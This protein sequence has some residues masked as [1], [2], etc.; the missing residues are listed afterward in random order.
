MYPTKFLCL[1]RPDVNRVRRTCTRQEVHRSSSRSVSHRSSAD[2]GRAWSTVDDIA[3]TS[4]K[5]TSSGGRV[6]KSARLS[7]AP[8]VFEFECGSDASLRPLPRR[9]RLADDETL[10]EMHEIAED[11]TLP[12]IHEIADRGFEEAANLMLTLCQPN[13]MEKHGKSR[14]IQSQIETGT[15][16]AI[17]YV[18]EEIY[19]SWGVLPTLE[20][21]GYRCETEFWAQ[22]MIS[23]TRT[24][25]MR[26]PTPD[27]S[28]RGAGMVGDNSESA[29]GMCSRVVRWVTDCRCY[30]GGVYV[31]NDVFLR[32]CG[33]P[34]HYTRHASDDTEVII[35][36][37]HLTPACLGKKLNDGRKN[38]D[39]WWLW[40]SCM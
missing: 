27:H 7:H 2:G 40:P 15:R 32:R 36:L 38:G 22:A 13:E 25:K 35:L 4:C 26:K 11:E 29:H 16:R 10:P 20:T 33:R 28:R 5:A 17:W 21:V 12:E 8:G 19:R 23:G 34:L 37:P 39:L 18:V 31:D 14:E 24:R 30:S 3:E 9:R 6:R 1:H